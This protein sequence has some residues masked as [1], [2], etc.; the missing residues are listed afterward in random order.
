MEGYKGILEVTENEAIT[1]YK[2]FLNNLD[3]G[4]SSA[5]E[6]IEKIEAESYKKIDEIKKV[7]D[8]DTV[9]K[10]VDETLGYYRSKIE[11]L[12][13]NWQGP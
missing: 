1:I 12:Q 13:K 5:L 11:Q 3:A 2:D 6:K 8:A 9:K 7:E 4:A 10:E